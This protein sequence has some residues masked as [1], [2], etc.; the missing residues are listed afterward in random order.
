MCCEEA[1]MV[2]GTVYFNLPNHTQSLF[3]WT[4]RPSYAL[5]R[6]GRWVMCMQGMSPPPQPPPPCTFVCVP[7]MI[8]AN[9]CD[10]QPDRCHSSHTV[11]RVCAP[12][13]GLGLSIPQKPRKLT[14]RSLIHFQMPGLFPISSFTLQP[15]E[16]KEGGAEAKASR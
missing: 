5:R 16:M 9:R 14:S 10:C 4:C 13:R 3:K 12:A 8:T 2:A 6:R 15:S 1:V 11:V 7:T